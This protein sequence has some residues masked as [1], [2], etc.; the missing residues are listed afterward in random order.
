M[1][2]LPKHYSL[3]ST[4]AELKKN[5]LDFLS[6]DPDRVTDNK[7]TLYLT[8]LLNLP[9]SS[10]SIFDDTEWDFNLENP[11]A[12]A[13]ITGSKLK[14][15][16]SKYKNIPPYVIIELKCM[17]LSVQLTP[18]VFINNRKKA[19]KAN[20]TKLATNTILGHFKSGFR[21]LDTLF[22]VLK[23][24]LGNEHIE[25]IYSS[26]TQV[27][28]IDY[29]ETAQVHTNTY[30]DDLR[31]FFSYLLNPYTSEHIF[32]ENI[33]AFDP[34]QFSW[35]KR[36]KKKVSNQV[37]PNATFDKLIRASSLIVHDFLQTME[38]EVLDSYVSRYASQ[39]ETQYCNKAGITK[40]TFQLYRAFRLL[41]AGYEDSYIDSKYGI[42]D[43][44]RNS[45]GKYNLKDMTSYL[46]RCH[47]FNFSLSKVNKHLMLVSSAAKYLIGQYT[48]MRPSE[49]A[50]IELH[51][52]LTEES[53][54]KLLRSHVFKGKDTSTK[55]LFDDKWVVIPIIEDAIRAIKIL[56][57]ITQRS[58]MFSSLHTKKN[59]EKEK[60][61]TSVMIR[62][63][64]KILIK[65][66]S[67]DDDLGFSNSM[68]RHTLAYQLYRLEAGLPLI[69]FQLKHLVNTVDKFLSRGS[70]SD[71]TMGYGGIAD[72]LVESQ[73]A[74][75]LRKQSE[76]EVIKA[77]ADPDGNYLGGKADEHKERL[78]IAFRGY[79]ASGY[80]KEE[81]FEAMA[82]QGLGVIN[83]G[84]GYCYG[85]DSNNESL[86]CIGS[87]RCNPNRCSNAIVSEA[88]APYWREIYSTNLANLNNPSFAD[89]REQIKEVI[90]EAKGVLT[91]LGHGVPNE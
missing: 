78:K 34:D 57:T 39:T 33:P 37:I 70:T 2:R 71:V 20:I 49:L 48:G 14:I 82:E 7:S 4:I 63:Q 46:A 44:L 77:T 50:V 30:N 76:I 87:L 58:L 91:L 84:L 12:S 36:Y 69:S 59:N 22:R 16:F 43:E 74:Q 64:I 15:N 13:N 61:Q 17:L 19:K 21:L 9:V 68:M 42:P 47:G 10:I 67:P 51:S 56:S 80:S 45:R 31:Q 62:H 41:S 3:L 73:T 88:N 90:N 52:C 35:K 40:Y 83:V 23:V 38:E 25:K 75:K 66:V 24:K 79:M 54:I 26:L 72:S 81:I 27:Q 86:P 85:S 55:G 11:N 1:E 5:K 18:E 28:A 32:G 6:A 29:R 89:N 53:G 60:L 8:K 65:L